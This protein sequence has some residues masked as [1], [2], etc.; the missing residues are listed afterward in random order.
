MRTHFAHLGDSIIQR[1]YHSLFVGGD[2]TLIKVAKSSYLKRLEI[3][4]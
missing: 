3:D 2:L 1:G 4:V